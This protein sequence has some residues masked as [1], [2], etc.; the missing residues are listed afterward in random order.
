MES[1]EYLYEEEFVNGEKLEVHGALRLKVK[2]DHMNRNKSR[3]GKHDQ[4]YVENF[5]P[6]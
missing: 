2:M 6:I 5:A 1:G 4:K 3:P